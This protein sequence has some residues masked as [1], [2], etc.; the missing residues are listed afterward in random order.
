[1][2]KD[3]IKL[4]Q[5]YFEQFIN[6]LTIRKMDKQLNISLN[7][8]SKNPIP[9]G[10]KIYRNKLNKKIL[11]IIDKVFEE[12][13]FFI[14]ESIDIFKFIND[15]FYNLIKEYLGQ[16]V[17]LVRIEIDNIEI[18]NRV[19]LDVSEKFHTDNQ[20]HMLKLYMCCEGYGSIS[21]NYLPGTQ[22]KLYEPNYFENL[23][24]IKNTLPKSYK[25][26]KKIDYF[27][28]DCALFDTNIKHRGDYS[29]VKNHKR[30][31]LV[32]SFMNVEKANKLG[33]KEIPQFMIFKAKKAPYRDGIISPNFSNLPENL[34]DKFYSYKFFIKD[35]IK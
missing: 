7:D 6:S 9:D 20:G 19:S 14:K 1:M 34:K 27:T 8:R 30:K 10:V 29:N 32:F 28:G 24:F 16:D 35:W 2:L 31:S 21:T 17:G 23:R 15:D 12:N 5:N 26:E 11:G 13:N 25:T 33:F 3:I 4:N 18:E 22:L